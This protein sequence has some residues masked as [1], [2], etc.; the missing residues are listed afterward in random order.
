MAS[1]RT[2]NAL[3]LLAGLPVLA[4]F[5]LPFWLGIGVMKWSAGWQI[6]VIV[7]AATAIALAAVFVVVRVQ[8]RLAPPAPVAA[9]YRFPTREETAA[10]HAADIARIEADPALHHWLPLAR[11]MARFDERALKRYEERYR[12]L[13]AHPT[14]HVYAA[15]LLDGDWMENDEMEW[16]E[17]PERSITCEHLK[18][19]ERELRRQGVRCIPADRMDLWCAA[20]LDLNQLKPRFALPDFVREVHVDDHPHHPGALYLRCDRCG[21][22]IESGGNVK[23]A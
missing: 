2:A 23:L 3:A 6:A 12:E 22:S 7:A 13:L 5:P 19:I 10:L 16:I 1:T 18:P 14:R 15:R 9:P 20:S 4:L 11:R 21:S 8:N 17:H